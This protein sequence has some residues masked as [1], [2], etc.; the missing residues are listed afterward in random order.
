MNCLEK[1]RRE[2]TMGA[3]KTRSWQGPCS[4]KR[5]SQHIAGVVSVRIVDISFAF[6][7]LSAT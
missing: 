1:K 5:G 4:A 2:E 7:R 6:A 3:V